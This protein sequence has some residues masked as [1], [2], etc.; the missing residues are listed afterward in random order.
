[1]IEPSIYPS[2]HPVSM[3]DVSLTLI[4][5]YREVFYNLYFAILLD[6]TTADVELLEENFLDTIPN[7]ERFKRVKIIVVNVPCSKSGIVNPVDFVLQ[8]G[9]TTSIKELAQGNVD[10]SKVKGLAFQHTNMLRHAMKFPLLQGVVYVTRSSY[11]V[12]NENVVKKAVEEHKE[13][14]HRDN[15]FFDPAPVLP[16]LAQSL[17][18]CGQVADGLP[19]EDISLTQKGKYF[20]CYSYSVNSV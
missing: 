19:V 5:F 1:M 18:M 3:Y 4:I 16:D 17:R 12:E 8:E 15:T 7:D 14:H 10:S 2:I 11:E 20:I 13:E 6:S 9:V